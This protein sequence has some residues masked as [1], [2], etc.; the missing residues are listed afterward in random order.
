MC[1]SLPHSLNQC[2]IMQIECSVPSKF[3]SYAVAHS[4]LES[5]VLVLQARH[6]A[7]C[8]ALTDE[9]PVA[10]FVVYRL[11]ESFLMEHIHLQK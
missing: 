10:G 3:L 6:G 4:T 8:C 2:P 5:L 7:E 11:Y 1:N 9:E